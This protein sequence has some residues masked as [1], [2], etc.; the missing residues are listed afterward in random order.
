ML[1]VVRTFSPSCH[2]CSGPGPKT[3]HKLHLKSGRYEVVLTFQLQN[4]ITPIK[5]QHTPICKTICEF[6]ENKLNAYD[7]WFTLLNNRNPDYVQL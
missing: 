1:R 2:I 3:I 7:G 6:K 5:L 4:L